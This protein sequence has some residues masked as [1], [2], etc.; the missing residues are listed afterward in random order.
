LQEQGYRI[1]FFFWDSVSLCSTGCPGTHS[2]DQTV[3]ELRNV[4]ASASQ[5][6]G[7]KSCSTTAWPRMKLKRIKSFYL[8]IFQMLP[9]QYTVV[10]ERV[11]G[12]SLESPRDLG[13]E[14]LPGLIGDAVSQNAQQWGTR[15]GRDHF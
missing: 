10:W 4:P 1:K 15:T 6:L 7:L 3:L 11:Q 8:F 2:V 12:E 13:H 9:T 5:V 14:R